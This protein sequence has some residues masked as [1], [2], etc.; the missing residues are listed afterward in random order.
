MAGWSPVKSIV[1]ALSA[2][3]LL[4]LVGCD[5]GLTVRQIDSA[6]RAK[7]AVA[8]PSSEYT[9]QVKT[10][11][12][13]IG[14]DLYHPEISFTNLSEVSLTVSGV[15][16]A[17]KGVIYKTDLQSKESFPI[18]VSPGTRAFFSPRFS[19][20]EPVYK[21]FQEAGRVADPL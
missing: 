12:Q 9:L 5:P 4:P 16:L 7:N 2:A 20:N 10:T 15:E 17:A 18:L 19:L 1:K 21:T 6:Q 8:L 3:V 13:L 11:R 14:E